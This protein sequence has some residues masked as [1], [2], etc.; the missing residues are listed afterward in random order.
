MQGRPVLGAISGLLLGLFIAIDLQQFGVWP[1]D[2][3]TAYG[4]PVLGL[5][6]GL[7][8]ARVAPFGGSSDRHDDR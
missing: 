2:T 4:M 7:V 3:W 6:L 8:L 5:V 1:L